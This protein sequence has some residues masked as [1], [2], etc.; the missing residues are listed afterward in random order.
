MTVQAQINDVLHLY[1]DMHKDAYGFR[2]SPPHCETV[3]EAEDVVRTL[4]IM[5]ENAI[6]VQRH[7]DKKAWQKVREEIRSI[8]KLLNSGPGRAIRV[9]FEANGFKEPEASADYQ[10]CLG[11]R[12]QNAEHILW[13]RGVPVSKWNALV[14][15][16]V[17]A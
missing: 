3:A 11:H 8:M 13:E 1:S 15:R 16:A 5:V 4:D 10:P 2:A 7:E 6:A 17:P 9:W 14:R 12:R